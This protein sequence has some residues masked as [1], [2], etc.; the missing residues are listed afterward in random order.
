MTD[1]NVDWNDRVL[2]CRKNQGTG[3]LT[4]KILHYPRVLYCKSFRLL[5]L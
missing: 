5:R 1:A 4:D 3:L 2:L